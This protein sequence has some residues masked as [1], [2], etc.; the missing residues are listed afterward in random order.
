MVGVVGTHNSVIGVTVSGRSVHVSGSERDSE[1]GVPNV[2]FGRVGYFVSNTVHFVNLGG[3]VLVSA[4]V[5]PGNVP[6]QNFSVTAVPACTQLLQPVSGTN[7][8]ITAGLGLQPVVARV[9]DS[10]VPP[11]SV[12][13]ATVT[14]QEVVSGIVPPSDPVNLGGIL[15][16]RNPAPIIISSARFSITSDTNGQVTIPISSTN[17]S[18]STQ[19]Q[20][21]ATAGTGIVDFN[22]HSFA[23]LT[24]N[25]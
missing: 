3:G 6:C 4:C 15:I 16:S 2:C 8:V 12:I 25:N 20:R 22:L 17:A 5:Q 13:G 10:V 21:S 1:V 9:S 7:H 18:G 14:I 11:R 23:P 19:I 24:R